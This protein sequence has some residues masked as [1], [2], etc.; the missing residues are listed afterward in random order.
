LPIRNSMLHPVFRP[1]HSR[2]RQI[3]PRLRGQTRS[4]Q[5]GSC[6]PCSRD[7]EKFALK[8]FPPVWAHSK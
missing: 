3:R 5:T 2:S 4:S 7:E 1:L 6:Q 8:Q